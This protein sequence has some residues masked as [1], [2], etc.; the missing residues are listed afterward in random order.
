MN[1]RGHVLNAILLSIGLGY[2]FEPSGGV[3]TFR[4][5][6]EVSIPIVLGALFPDVDTAFGRHRKTLHNLLVLGVVAA[7]PIYFDN[8]QFVWMGVLT[9]YVLDVMGSRRGIA[10]FYP[11]L[12]TEYNLPFGVPVSSR[13]ADTVTVV[14]TAVELA[15]AAIVVFEV[16]QQ[17]ARMGL[18]A[19]GVSL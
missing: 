6:A 7:Y 12:D 16:P 19:V 13:K 5:I 8:L 14:V 17:L 9:H 4:T 3:E 1:K 18:A 10:L 11:V 15:V 2:V